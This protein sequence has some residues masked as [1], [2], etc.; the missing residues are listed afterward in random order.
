MKSLTW[1]PG[2]R[3]TSSHGTG[4][5]YEYYSSHPEDP[6]QTRYYVHGQSR[7]VS[8]GYGSVIS[9]S[10]SPLSH[11][12]A[13][14]GSRARSNPQPPQPGPSL[15]PPA[16]SPSLAEPPVYYTATRPT[17]VETLTSQVATLQDTVHR[18]QSALQYERQQR[19]RMNLDM[20]AYL[21]RMTD[22]L[23]E[24]DVLPMHR[25]AV[26][27]QRTDL[28]RRYEVLRDSE[29]AQSRPATEERARRVSF[30]QPPLTVVARSE[31][32]EVLR[33]PHD[34]RAAAQADERRRP[35][36]TGSQPPSY[37]PH[38]PRRTSAQYGEYPALGINARTDPRDDRFA[39]ETPRSFLYETRQDYD[40]RLYRPSPS[41][42][43][44]EPPP[45]QGEVERRRPSAPPSDEPPKASLRNLLH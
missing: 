3:P 4:G 10:E 6:G 7:P 36:T 15:A 35:S 33:E 31:Y 21:L 11:P 44:T 42:R 1:P 37:H 9:Q 25:D 43:V 38:M 40:R 20:S 17:T 18:L 23:S 32:Q 34:Y 14:F 16:Q 13:L 22:W 12:S 24:G 19:S 28:I 45:P 5:P 39:S 30:V 41:R 2:G 26:E 29:A 8:S 27:R